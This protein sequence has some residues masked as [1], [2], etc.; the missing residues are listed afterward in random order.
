MAR[1]ARFFLVLLSL[2][3]LTNAAFLWFNSSPNL[4]LYALTAFGVL[5]LLYAILFRG[6]NRLL[7]NRAGTVVKAL[8][9]LGFCFVFFISALITVSGRSDT[10]RYDEAAL[11]VLGAGLRGETPSRVLRYRL[12][13]AVQ[14]HKMNPEAYLVVSGGRGPYESITEAEGM[15]RYLVGQGVAEEKIVCEERATSTYENFLYSKELLDKLLEKPYKTAFVTNQFHVY[16]AGRIA[17]KAGLHPARLAAKS[18]W[19]T[20]LPDYLRECSAVMFMWC[21]G[22]MHDVKFSLLHFL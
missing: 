22:V 16:R 9:L 17:Q 12:D 13:K 19:I 1:I 15:R 14:Y 21:G 18:D 2:V 8:V 11:I 20:I 5:A 7:D 10:V 3:C 6:M 4:G